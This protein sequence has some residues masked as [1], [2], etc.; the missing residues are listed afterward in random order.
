MIFVHCQN[1]ISC[2]SEGLIPAS[3]KL[4]FDKAHKLPGHDSTISVSHMEIQSE[5]AYDLLGTLM[6]L[7]NY[8]TELPQVF[9]FLL[10]GCW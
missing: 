7:G 8:E 9:L 6:Y 4:I 3:L 2:R 1:I 10:T 5:A